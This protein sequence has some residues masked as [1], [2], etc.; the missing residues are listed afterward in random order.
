MKA[1][2]KTR[3]AAIAVVA[4]MTAAY[5][6]RDLK[7]LTA[8]FAPD[9][10][11]VLIGTG[12]DETRFGPEQIALQAKRDWDQ[13]DSIAIVLESTAVS[14]AGPVAWV[15][16]DGAFNIQAGGQSMVLPARMTFVLECRNDDWLIVHA[17]FSTPAMG[18]EEGA[19][20]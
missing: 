8:C 19:S 10:D 15:F 12:A 13:T 20:V 2:A 9:D 4:A 16:A 18:Q 3:E 6:A 1:D 14:S 5:K 17:H 11:V 7:G